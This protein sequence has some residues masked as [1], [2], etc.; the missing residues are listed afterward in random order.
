LP[1]RTG[2]PVLPP[3]T[4]AWRFLF[5]AGLAG[6]AS[7]VPGSLLVTSRLLGAGQ[8]LAAAATLAAAA[9]GG[10]LALAV[11]LLLPVPAPAAGALVCLIAVATGLA[12]AWQETRLGVAPARLVGEGRLGMRVALW[13]LIVPVVWIPV[14]WLI[15]LST[16]RWG[17][18]VMSKPSLQGRILVSAVV[19]LMPLGAALGLARGFLGRRFRVASPI[20]FAAALPVI[21][22]SLGVA[23]GGARLLQRLWILPRREAWPPNFGGDALRFFGFGCLALLLVAAAEYLSEAASVRGF[24]IRS[25]AVVGVMLAGGVHGAVMN[26]SLPLAMRER[27]ADRRAARGDDAAAAADW[28]WVI[29]RAPVAHGTCRAIERC[30][31]SALRAG[32]AGLARWA[33][34][35]ARGEVIG[36]FP[37]SATARAAAAVLATNLGTGGVAG[38]N[39]PSVRPESYLSNSWCAVL[40][41]VRAA[42]PEL[43]EVRLKNRLQALSSNPDEIDLPA[44][45]GFDDLRWAVR[46]LG[47][48]PLV[49]PV[50]R[51]HELLGQGRPV[52]FRDPISKTWGVIVWSAPD[53]DAVLW[54]DYGRWDRGRERPLSR[55]EVQQ[56]V[57]SVEPAE[58]DPGGVRAEVGRLGAASLLKNVLA[59]DGGWVVVAVPRSREGAFET[60]AGSRQE[61][62]DDLALCWRARHAVE[63]RAWLLAA[64]L[65]GGLP[66]GPARDEI[67][68]VSAFGTR[69][70]MLPDA[71]RTP[72][73]DAALAAARLLRSGG[74]KG[75][76]PWALQQIEG[77]AARLPALGCAVHR[78][79]LEGLLEWDPDDARILEKLLAHAVA[80]ER[81]EDVVRLAL[82][83]ARARWFGPDSVLSALR[84]VAPLEEAPS[85]RGALEGLLRRLPRM[86]PKK[87]EDLPVPRGTLAP[88]CAARAALAPRPEDAVEWWRRAVEI[89]PKRP[90]YQRRLSAALAAA[91]MDVEA[92]AASARYREIAGV[93][94]CGE[95]YGGAGYDED[96]DGEGIDALD[97][98]GPRASRGIAR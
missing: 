2:V 42:R 41:A 86:V 93:E 11:A 79:A 92:A 87:A 60:A 52:L 29:R 23:S 96:G 43:S 74:L 67:L 8:S 30:A 9:A 95:A 81:G 24:L 71:T 18:E 76:S 5:H 32:D 7:P 17:A 82:D 61:V 4:P 58:Q 50:A 44:M 55:A 73:A 72:P 75:L 25:A 35:Q 62:G 15:T 19:W 90:A 13:G 84:V 36:Q 10:L 59:A 89:D 28:A 33:L 51:A 64:R 54:L 98:T 39:V 31:V 77:L 22:V 83:L 37:C 34:E 68:A 49:V 94:R 12:I 6:M 66:A 38:V 1:D 70:P 26:S 47:G 69:T 48:E 14:A 63:K 56:L 65:A 21:A 3:G 88:Y 85:A 40:T 46:L 80:E 57:S 53:A 20:I 97:A 27:A 91:G 45:D 78:D 16:G